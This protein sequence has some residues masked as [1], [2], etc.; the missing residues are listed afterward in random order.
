MLHK[1]HLGP[2]KKFRAIHC[3]HKYMYYSE[4][5]MDRWTLLHSYGT[6]IWSQRAFLTGK[7]AECLHTLDNKIQKKTNDNN[8]PEEKQ[9]NS[10]KKRKKEKK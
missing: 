4:K 9:N 10:K 8:L 5:Q 1:S 6:Y 7:Q 2:E 3:V